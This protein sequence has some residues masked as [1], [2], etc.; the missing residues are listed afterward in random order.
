MNKVIIFLWISFVWPNFSNA[1]D[2]NDVQASIKRLNQIIAQNERNDLAGKSNL[3]QYV[4]FLEEKEEL[5]KKDSWKYTD[6][7]IDEVLSRANDKLL[8]I[9]EERGFELFLLIDGSEILYQYSSEREVLN[10]TKLNEENKKEIKEKKQGLK[11]KAQEIFLGSRAGSSSALTL[12]AP[13]EIIEFEVEKAQATLPAQDEKLSV[14][15]FT[16]IANGKDFDVDDF[17]DYLRQKFK[18]KSIANIFPASFN[19]AIEKVVELLEES[20]SWEV[21]E[22]LEPS[23]V[24]SQKP[25]VKESFIIPDG[26]QFNSVT[27]AD[28]NT[29]IKSMADDLV[30]A[31]T[32]YPQDEDKLYDKGNDYHIIN[33][34][35]LQLENYEASDKQYEILSDKLEYLKEIENVDVYVIYHPCNFILNREDN[36]YNYFAEAVYNKVESHLNND[37]FVLITIPYAYPKTITNNNFQYLMPG[38]Y[39]TQGVLNYSDINSLNYVTSFD[40]AYNV[41][42]NIE[43]PYNLYYGVLNVDGSIEY[44]KKSISRSRNKGAIN[45]IIYYINPGF[46][47]LRSLKVPEHNSIKAFNGQLKDNDPFGNEFFKYELDIYLYN[48]NRDLILQTYQNARPDNSWIKSANSIKEKYIEEYFIAYGHEFI[49]NQSDFLVWLNSFA[50]PATSDSYSFVGPPWAKVPYQKLIEYQR[51]NNKSFTDITYDFDAF[52]VIDPIAYTLFDAAGLIPG[53]DNAA[54]AF[55]LI[56]AIGRGD[57]ENAIAYFVG[58][59]VVGGGAVVIKGFQKTGK[60]IYKG[61]LLAV[62]NSSGRVIKELAAKQVNYLCDLF[63]IQS[64]SI[65]PS[66]ILNPLHEAIE[67]KSL[68]KELYDEVI[69]SGT[70]T[71]KIAKLKEVMQTTALAT[72]DDASG[73]FKDL[74]QLKTWYNSPNLN[75]LKKSNIKEAFGELDIAARGRIEK[76]LTDHESYRQVFGELLV[77]LGNGNTTILKQISGSGWQDLLPKLLA[78]LGSSPNFR[79]K[80]FD[81][82]GWVDSWGILFKEAD[83]ISA[84]LRKNPENLQK[85]NDY[86]VAEGAD[87]TKLKST[88]KNTVYPEKWLE[89]KIPQSKLDEIFDAADDPLSWTAQHKAQKWNNYKAG[90]RKMDFASWSNN[91]DG[92]INKSVKGTDVTKNYADANGIDVP[93]GGFEYPHPKVNEVTLSDGSVVTGKR[94]HDIF[95]EYTKKAVEVKDYKSQKVYRSKEIEKEALMD[96]ELF[97]AGEIDD[98]DWIF[99]DKGP[100]GPLEQL[101]KTPVARADGKVLIL[102]K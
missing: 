45:E 24:A 40:L 88:F 73:L 47:S 92:N 94:R 98:M 53:I 74:P 2:T 62:K 63:K 84:A 65:F 51:G 13:I 86:I 99:L 97:K 80:F 39:A 56:Y 21:L 79:T 27:E 70:D 26:A 25:L 17:E 19:N 50:E 90:D 32:N 55:G 52:K 14:F 43:K 31:V 102:M 95:N 20:Y 4:F 75:T 33:R 61:V 68:T 44:Y 82:L 9:R 72:L 96:I 3:N 89:L 57:E 5:A 28:L 29:I 101:L 36:S 71:R 58:I 85:L 34:E 93:E 7:N 77:K 23:F 10:S 38:L 81:N 6:D 59:S 78:D 37:K 46:N 87:L 11:A 35:L 30:Q 49:F 41:Y 12:L 64:P 8:S 16:H 54:D 60:F 76:V 15:Y 83:E 18:E 67:N 66:E 48:I 1:N 69:E 22:E 100:S 42:K 91:Y